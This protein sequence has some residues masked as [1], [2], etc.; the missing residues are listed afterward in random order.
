MLGFYEYHI[1]S[2][3]TAQTQCVYVLMWNRLYSLHMIVL[4]TLTNGDDYYLHNI[5]TENGF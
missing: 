4:R 1:F 5:D 2:N 3:S